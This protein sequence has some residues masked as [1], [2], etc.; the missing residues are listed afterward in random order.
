MASRC[1]LILLLAFLASHVATDAMADGTV[2]TSQSFTGA[3]AAA[4]NYESADWDENPEFDIDNG[5]SGMASG[6]VVPGLAHAESNALAST[7]NGVVPNQVVDTLQ[8]V[9]SGISSGMVTQPFIPDPTESG[10]NAFFSSGTTVNFTSNEII[11]SWAYAAVNRGSVTSGD[12][13]H[14][15]SAANATA[16]APGAIANASANLDQ[17]QNYEAN[18]TATSSSAPPS[19]FE[20]PAGSV[21]AFAI[22]V[23]GGNGAITTQINGTSDVVANTSNEGSTTLMSAVAQ[24]TTVFTGQPLPQPANGMAAAVNNTSLEHGDFDF[25]YD[26]D[27]DDI[28]ALAA[29]ALTGPT[30]VFDGASG[31]YDLTLDTDVSY[32]TSAPGSGVHSDSDFIVRTLLGTDYGD[33]NLDGVFDIVDYTIIRANL[34]TS[35]G[36]ASGD[37]DGDGYVSSNDMVI[38]RAS[39]I[40]YGSSSLGVS[41]PEPVS[42]SVIFAA[43]FCSLGCRGRK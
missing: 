43:I 5:F 28:D 24:A 40:Y 39:R 27:A 16:T 22:G 42:V 30:S 14:A 29:A 7:F 3:H 9:S 21:A 35:G 12:V 6:A 8:A 36:W 20:G 38:F 2:Q 25:D 41:V 10:G 17:E 34:Y 19:T 15:I 4:W 18:L 33:A 37:F 13:R 11:V 31:L 1:K 23:G 26:F 32:T